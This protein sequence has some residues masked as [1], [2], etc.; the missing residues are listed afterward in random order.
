M[1][2]WIDELYSDVEAAQE[3]HHRGDIDGAW[4]ELRQLEV[5]LDKKTESVDLEDASTARHSLVWI[6]AVRASLCADVGELAL[7]DE[8]FSESLGRAWAYEVRKD[9]DEECYAVQI[10][11]VSRQLAAVKNWRALQH[12]SVSILVETCNRIS[13][14]HPDASDLSDIIFPALRDIDAY[15]ESLGYRNLNAH[16][17]FVAG[18]INPDWERSK[19][20]WRQ[21][22]SLVGRQFNDFAQRFEERV[23]WLRS[24]DDASGAE[25][26]AF[27][28]ERV[29][30]TVE[31]LLYAPRSVRVMRHQVEALF[32]QLIQSAKLRHTDKLYETW[33]EVEKSILS[34]IESAPEC[35]DFPRYFAASLYSLATSILAQRYDDDIERGQI[36]HFAFQREFDAHRLM[37]ARQRRAPVNLAEAI[38]WE[39]LSG[40]MSETYSMYNTEESI[41]FSK[42]F[43]IQRAII[44]DYI[45]KGDPENEEA[46]LLRQGDPSPSVARNMKLKLELARWKWDIQ[47]VRSSPLSQ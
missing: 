8:L 6:R 31:W 20:S 23:S 10:V 33:G 43:R 38:M 13:D 46:L 16:F 12:D 2:F 3:R 26:M 9:G 5:A 37:V 40:L 35:E 11:Q 39:R 18:T 21:P 15:G 41:K 4:K 29:V 44:L 22:A 27:A 17:D 19:S 47:P 28:N 32:D 36:V 25:K 42:S 30:T 14:S 45:L 7:A 24:K 34:L 1:D